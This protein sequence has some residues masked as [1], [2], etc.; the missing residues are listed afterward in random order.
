MMEQ[1]RDFF[2]P[3][4]R[5][6]NLLQLVNEK[7]KTIDEIFAGRPYNIKES[8]GFVDTEELEKL[9]L[10]KSIHVSDVY[11]VLFLIP[12]IRKVQR[13]RLRNCSAGIP[14]N[15]DQWV[16]NIPREY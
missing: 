12:G 8:H 1:L 14:S 10:R 9:T 4:P 15:L 7:K 11:N 16:I 3:S 13:L 6:Y 5:F 2:S